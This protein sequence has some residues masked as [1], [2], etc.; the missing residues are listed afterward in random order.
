MQ[1]SPRVFFLACCL[2][3][4]L[5]CQADDDKS[6]LS[7]QWDA[8]SAELSDVWIPRWKHIWADGN[9]EL[10]LPFKTYHMRW[11]YTR[12]KIDSYQELPFGL[13]YGRALYDEKENWHG[14]YAMGFQDSHFKPQWMVGYGW[15]AMC[16][17][18]SSWNAGAGYTVF[19]AS[20]TDIANYIPFP[21]ILPIASFGYKKLSIEGAYVP[22]GKGNGNV[23]FMWGKWSFL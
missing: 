15:K 12:E 1:T 17:S 19:F 2:S 8:A 6:W 5:S 20:R 9:S 14:L 10:Y 21:S 4:S 16:G 13:G 11:A 18:R 3:T 23:V 22:G 7:R